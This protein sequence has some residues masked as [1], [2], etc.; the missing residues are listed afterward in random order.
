[1]NNEEKFRKIM[2]CLS[3]WLS[4]HEKNKQIA[5]YLN[6]YQIHRVGVY[7]YGILGKHLVR[8][9]Q[10]Q[11]FPISWVVDRSASNDEACCNLVRPGEMDKLEDV[12]MAII[13]TLA[14]VE[15]VE[16]DLLKFVT[17]KIISVEELID[18]IY[19]WRNQT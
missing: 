6:I 13:T 8:E 15:T 18:S 1:M 10:A 2:R 19:G 11:D 4:N 17:G 7:G 12:D 5:D 16:S 9:L 14:D 3:K